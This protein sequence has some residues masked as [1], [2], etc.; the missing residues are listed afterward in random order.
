MQENEFWYNDCVMSVGVI[1]MFLIACA[2][3][4]WAHGGTS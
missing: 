1:I 3:A 2:I 4:W